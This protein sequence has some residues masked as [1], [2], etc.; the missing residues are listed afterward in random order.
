MYIYVNRAENVLNQLPC[1]HTMFKCIVCL[2]SCWRLIRNIDTKLKMGGIILM[3][4]IL[5][6]KWQLL[7]FGTRGIIHNIG[8][9]INCMYNECLF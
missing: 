5:Q 9:Y 8:L 2:K 7:I 6:D 4:Y 3:S 1:T